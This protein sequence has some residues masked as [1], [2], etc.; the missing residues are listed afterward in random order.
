MKDGN[1][2]I[3]DLSTLRRDLYFVVSL[4]LA[5]EKVVEVK[6]IAIWAKAFHEAEV[7]RLM[8]WVAT[9]NRGLLDLPNKEDDGFGAQRCGEY[10]DDFPSG[11]VVMQTHSPEVRNLS[12]Q[13]GQ[14]QP[15]TTKAA[16]SINFSELLIPVQSDLSGYSVVFCM[17]SA[18]HAAIARLQCQDEYS[19]RWQT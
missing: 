7:R 13:S 12:R 8:L 11:T 18:L 16:S 10:W 3:V 19:M 6:N 17:V 9:A 2:P 14:A 4:L 5:D 15:E 1:V